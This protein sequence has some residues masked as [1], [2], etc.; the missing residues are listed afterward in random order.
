MGSRALGQ[1]RA[2]DRPSVEVPAMNRTIGEM[3]FDA[4]VRHSSI[5]AVRDPHSREPGDL[6][7]TQLGDKVR[8]LAGGLLTMGVRQGERIAIL[9]DNCPR[10][11]LCDIAMLAIGAVT[12]PRGS[13][14]ATTELEYILDHS[15]A[16]VV[17]VQTH[18]L[19]ERMRCVFAAAANV[20]TIIM[21]DDSAAK[22]EAPV[23]VTVQDLQTIADLGRSGKVGVG[24]PSK[25]VTPADLATIVYTSGT[26]GVP[27]GVMLT[28][29]NLTHQSDR[30]GIGS[31]PLPADMVLVLL[32]SWHAYERAVEYIALRHGW[33]LTYTDKRH[34]RDDMATIR[35]QMLPCVPRIWESVFDV[36]Q[37]GLRRASP[38]K[39]N[40]VRFLIAASHRF[41]WARRTARGV[42]LRR[43]PANPVTRAVAAIVAAAL[44]PLHRLAD[45][46]AY[47]S[48]RSATGG[49][50][51]AA[52]S[53]GGSLA[54]YIDDF[55][56]VLG[57]PILNGY[58]LTET[59]PVLTL[60]VLEHNVRGSVGR[61]VNDTEISIRDES[62]AELEQGCTGVVWAR[63]PQ[64]MSGYYR[65][66]EATRAVLSDDGWVN[67]GDLGWIAAT[68]DLVIAGRAKDT[69]VLTSGENVEPEH[70]E[71]V[72]RQSRFV[73]QIVVV[74]QD[75]KAIGALVVPEF[76][77][78]AA[79]LGLADA[80]TPAELAA[81][82][83]ASKLVRESVN[84]VLQED[85]GFK[86]GELISRVALLA[87]PFSEA[88][89]MLTQTLKV[90][91]RAVAEQHA[92]IIRTM[93][94]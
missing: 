86:P 40:L 30:I 81:L 39:R 79:E 60:R 71:T 45:V 14:T 63:G 3:F 9:S 36:I 48:I 38:A 84:A 90:R 33:T 94:G 23:G 56:E 85:G 82:P 6:T 43:H 58:G 77:L 78:L 47:R 29:R 8:A 68:G 10:W 31:A 12:V 69:I 13:E 27:K 75:Q 34:F 26:T 17:L 24:I 83:A 65:N 59:A 4:A 20:R 49:R 28:H 1:P 32:P 15:E 52:V 64:V 41:V 70:V 21:M 67:T 93:Y 46:L 53:G 42:D 89:G 11:I 87:E 19:F 35:P 91:R 88:N 50:L 7:Y 55:F 73:N 54:S 44:Y 61:P 62:G 74:G 80:T 2:G 25:T 57:I 16:S 51:K 5:T 66:E 72:A 18:R 76:A 37:D 92:Q 22:C